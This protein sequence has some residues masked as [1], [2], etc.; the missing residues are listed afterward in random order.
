MLRVRPIVLAL[1]GGLIFSGTAT[2]Q[3]FS[4]N[5][6]VIQG[7]YKC[8][9]TTYSLPSKASDPFPVTAL[10]EA[11]GVADGRGKWT[12]GEWRQSVDAPAFHANCHLTMITGTYSVR[13]NGP[14][15][16]LPNGDW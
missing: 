15:R 2:A 1:L 3:Q 13:P 11:T 6:A 8:T 7:A 10:G 9:V 16:E 5:D 12:S 14:E 4:F